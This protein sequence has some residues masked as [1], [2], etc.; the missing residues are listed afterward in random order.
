MQLPKGELMLLA[1]AVQRSCDSAGAG[2]NDED[3]AK[4][5]ALIRLLE[6]AQP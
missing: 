4:L 6:S 1:P 2:Q 5:D 3:R